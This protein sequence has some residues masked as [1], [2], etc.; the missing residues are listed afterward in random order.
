[1]RKIILL[2]GIF[3]I[4]TILFACASKS[5]PAEKPGLSETSAKESK[6]AE[7]APWEVEWVRSLAEAKKEGRVTIYTGFAPS[8]KQELGKVFKNKFDISIEWVSGT[9]S[10]ITEKVFRERKAGIYLCD[11]FTTGSSY[12]VQMLR[13]AGVLEPLDKELLLPEV[14]DSR[15]WRDNKLPFVDKEH[16]TMAPSLTPA[17]TIIINTILVKEGEIQS[18]LDLLQP[19]WKGKIVM[20]N[21]S[22]PGPSARWN[23]AVGNLI[24]DW[25]FI[26]KLA[27]QLELAE[28]S[29]LVAEYVAKGKKAIALAPE[30]G[31]VID[32]I[33]ASAPIAMIHP[34]EGV[35][36]TT[37][38]NNIS[39]L[40]DR[41][42]PYSAR[43]FLNW[44]L[45]KEGQS[46]VAQTDMRQTSR[47]DIPE[48]ILRQIPA[49]KK[50]QP[51][52]KYFNTETEEFLAMEEES[53]KK[54]K[55]IY[56][57]LIR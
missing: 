41:P 4:I 51:G 28:D 47:L 11:I 20:L 46:I 10:L 3:I 33:E 53:L 45:S 40:R 39:L 7:R 27:K 55:E 24:M 9:G 37:G 26:E 5:A 54:I 14:T 25:E 43:L 36:E 30:A 34:K 1:M 32:F 52:V 8:A 16:M 49:I 50:R 31:I 29:R 12:P 22:R 17:T 44:F 2:S 35:Y 19:K 6:S 56:G 15:M 42:H 48:E 18:Y 57:P 13:P 23:T 21:P 38:Q